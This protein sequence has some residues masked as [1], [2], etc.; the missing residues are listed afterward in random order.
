MFIC[1]K[2]DFVC[3]K[4]LNIYLLKE[5]QISHRILFIC[6]F[7]SLKYLTKIFILQSRIYS[8]RL[9]YSSCTV[10]FF[11]GNHYIYNT[12]LLTIINA[13]LWWQRIEKINV[14]VLL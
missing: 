9:L 1:D 2:A 8:V 11:L 3:D 6:W 5:F 4:K 14:I 13:L 10:F 7:Y 12:F